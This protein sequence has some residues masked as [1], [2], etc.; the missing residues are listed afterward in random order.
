MAG[1]SLSYS[2]KAHPAHLSLWLRKC[3]PDYIHSVSPLMTPHAYAEVPLDSQ[4]KGRCEMERDGREIDALTVFL[5]GLGVLLLVLGPCA[6]LYSIGMGLVGMV[7]CWVLAISMRV[8]YLGGNRED[9]R[10]RYS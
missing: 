4:I 5:M 8:F 7:A 9:R 1:S 3:S 2:L 6:D 10:Y